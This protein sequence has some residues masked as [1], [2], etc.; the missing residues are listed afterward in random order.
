MEQKASPEWVGKRIRLIEMKDTDPVP[1]GTEGTIIRVDTRMNVVE[2]DWDIDRSL[3][4]CPD[5]DKF[6]FI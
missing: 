5:I 1:S 4:I 6:E 2:V 3:S